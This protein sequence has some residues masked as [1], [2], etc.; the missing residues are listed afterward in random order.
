[1]PPAPPAGGAAAAAASLRELEE[2]AA[3]KKERLEWEA[4]PAAGEAEEAERARQRAAGEAPSTEDSS[5]VLGVN[6][7]VKPA[8][9]PPASATA[10][11]AL[12][13]RPAPVAPVS[14]AGSL[15]ALPL[16]ASLAPLAPASALATM[17]LASVSAFAAAPRPEAQQG[18]AEAP[19]EFAL[20]PAAAPQRDDLLYDPP[21]L[22]HPV[23]A[24]AQGSKPSGERVVTS[25]AAALSRFQLDRMEAD[26]KL[27]KEEAARRAAA[28]AQQE[29][30]QP[31]GK[32]DQKSAP[33]SVVGVF[34]SFNN[35]MF[36]GTPFKK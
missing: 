14:A 29:Q 30:Q 9:L 31:A 25:A 3:L 8:A 17:A 16:P 4:Q 35:K 34:K 5:S 1:M 33:A 24:W 18:G 26:W 13:V 7:N 32:V 27:K 11:P 28:K 19:F 36:E 21:P 20:P 12:P 10:P 6:P 15:Q 22:T 2:E 23:P